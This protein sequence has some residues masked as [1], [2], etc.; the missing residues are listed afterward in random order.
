[1][2]RSRLADAGTNV[3]SLLAS[4]F[5]FAAQHTLISQATFL[6]LRVRSQPSAPFL[7]LLALRLASASP[8]E[9]AVKLPSQLAMTRRQYISIAKGELRRS[10][11]AARGYV[12]Y[13]RIAGR[14]GRP[15]GEGEKVWDGYSRHSLYIGRINTHTVVLQERSA[16]PS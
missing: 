6:H 8:R 11:A 7:L 5:C 2:A 13:R 9:M 15:F 4:P 10:M 16:T 3:P 14:G 12:P 1:M